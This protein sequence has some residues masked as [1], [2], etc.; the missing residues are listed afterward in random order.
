LANMKA[1]GKEVK[2]LTE[3]FGYTQPTIDTRVA[4]GESLKRVNIKT[5]YILNYMQFVNYILP[6]RIPPFIT[7]NGQAI[8]STGVDAG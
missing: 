7:H 8:I 2:E 5:V 6:L 3:I 4:I 1:E